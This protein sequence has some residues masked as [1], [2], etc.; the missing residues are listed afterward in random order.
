MILLA[1]RQMLWQASA[2]CCLGPATWR[3]VLAAV[4]E[5]DI[6]FAVY[7]NGDWFGHHKLSFNQGN[8][9]L[10]V[11]IEIAF[12]YKLGFIP[13]YRYR[14]RNREVWADGKLIEIDTETDDN[15]TL[16]EVLGRSDGER[17][18]IEGADGKLDLPGD[19]LPSSYWHEA[20][21]ERETWLDTQHGRLLRSNVTRK[22]NEQIMVK[23]DTVQA[24]AY[25]LEGDLTCTLW[26]HENHWVGLR[27]LAP[28][29]S[30]IDYR[31]EPVG[32][33]G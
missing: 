31:I 26:Y 16:Y 10:T 12:D 6:D 21:V 14:H 25:E 27:F 1:R 9:R 15:G 7:R 8:D 32:Q 3:S 11:D 22:P 23:D 20:T 18:R 19:T 13:L 5:E 2:I 24:S 30:V 29:D 17:L 33:S 4:P 28:D